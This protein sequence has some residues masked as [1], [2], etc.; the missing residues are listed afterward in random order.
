MNGL[1]DVLTPLLCNVPVVVGVGHGVNF[2]ILL[3]AE[4]DNWHLFLKDVQ[5]LL[6]SFQPETLEMVS[7]QKIMCSGQRPGP[8]PLFDDLSHH[9][10]RYPDVMG[11][12][13]HG[14]D[15]IPGY[16]ALEDIDQPGCC[17]RNWHH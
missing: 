3:I 15:W 9:D 12:G 10:L 8:Q 11:H 2:E 7:K 14:P 13:P 1:G 16:P 6:R 4:Q 5:Q 17:H